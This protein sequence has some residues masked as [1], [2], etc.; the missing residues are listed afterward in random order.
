LLFISS[1]KYPETGAASIRHMTYARGLVELGHEVIF[2]SLTKQDICNYDSINILDMSNMSKCKF[3]IV[4][5]LL[6]YKACHNYI[7]QNK[8]KIDVITILTIDY[9]AIY[10]LQ[11]TARK[12][13]I[14]VI[15]ERTE[16]PFIIKPKIPFNNFFLRKYLTEL[17]PRFDGLYVINKKLISYFQ[18]KLSS[19]SYIKEVL[20]VVD[21][22]LFEKSKHTN[23]LYNFEYFAYCG[24]LY[25]DKDG[26]DILIKSFINFSQK[27]KELK[28]LVVGDNSEEERLEHIIKL[29]YGYEDKII[30]TGLL[31]REK[32]ANV[33]TNAKALLLAR[34]ANKQAEGGF[35]SKLGE[36]LSTGNPVVITNVGEISDYL[37]DGISA[38][39]AEPNSVESFT[40]KLEEAYKSPKSKIIGE[41]GKEIAEKYFNYKKQAVNLSNFFREVIEKY[42]TI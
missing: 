4:N 27:Y 2:L 17:I 7:N 33:L 16:Y 28:L 10:L 39:I 6:S 5:K 22:S 37:D 30:F 14:P 29:L 24:T 15:H 42:R 38:F 9:F 11:K 19:N 21:M 8:S 35:P 12:C 41:K 23:R 18:T 26:L 34:P 20:T 36:Y 25:G 3:K 13:R 32:L 31:G 40:K 1:N